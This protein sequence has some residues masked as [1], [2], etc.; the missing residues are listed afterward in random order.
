[1]SSDEQPGSMRREFEFEVESTG[2]N[3]HQVEAARKV[4]EFLTHWEYR[5]SVL[6]DEGIIRKIAYYVDGQKVDVTLT[7]EDLRV[8][9][10]PRRDAEVLAR[11]WWASRGMSHGSPDRCSCGVETRPADGDEDVSDR[12][13]LAFA[14]H[15]AEMLEISDG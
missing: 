9:L 8:L 6:G 11:H 4:R 13:A 7:V 15:Q 3:A 14:E 12:R 2:C 5:M 10:A 1:M